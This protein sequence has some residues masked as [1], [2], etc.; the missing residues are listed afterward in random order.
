ML[1]CAPSYSSPTVRALSSPQSRLLRA[2]LCLALVGLV[3]A[4][5]SHSGYRSA[6]GYRAGRTY[7]PPGPP[8]DPWGPYI[9]EASLRFQVPDTWIRAVMRQESGGRQYGSGGGL[10]TSSAGA[11]GLMQVMPETYDGLRAR[12]DLGEDPY[13]PHNNILAG[14]AYIREMYDRYG[15]PGFLAAYNAGP[16]RLDR[17]LGGSTELPDETVNYVASV[18]PRLGNTVAMSGPLSVYADPGNGR[19][20]VPVETAFLP[21]PV[22]ARATQA[23]QVLDQSGPAVIAMAPIA[24]PGDYEPAPQPDAAIRPAA[25]ETAPAPVLAAPLPRAFPPSLGFRFVASAPPAQPFRQAGIS[26]RLGDPGRRIRQSGPGAH[27]RRH[28]PHHGRRAATG[29]ATHGRR[30]DPPGRQRLYR[31]RVGGLSG[32][33]ADDACRRLRANGRD[34]LVVPPQGTS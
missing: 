6:R 18:A 31:A 23:P 30:D 1:C 19:D 24:S 7:P 12:Y 25:M 34:C 14:S 16:N 8:S 10:T 4:C 32:P 20:F 29:R 22:P 3:S 21:D 28:G 11:M 33:V 17:Y 27:R 5:A 13:D 2:G 26:W 15:S 9:R